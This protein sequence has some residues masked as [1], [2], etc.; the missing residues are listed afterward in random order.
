MG[1]K[2]L[3]LV[4]SLIHDLVMAVKGNTMALQEEAPVRE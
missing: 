2:T 4:K 1:A 3:A